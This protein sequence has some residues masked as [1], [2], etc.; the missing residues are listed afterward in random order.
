MFRPSE[1]IIDWPLGHLSHNGGL[2]SLNVFIDRPD[3]CG[4]HH[5]SHW[6]VIPLSVLRTP[7]SHYRNEP[8]TPDDVNPPTLSESPPL[9]PKYCSHIV[10]PSALPL[11]RSS[12]GP[13]PLLPYLSEPL[14]SPL[15]VTEP[16]AG[17]NIR[18]P[19][20]YYYMR[21]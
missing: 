3:T 20:L 1:Q 5:I 2:T 13:V 9:L 8:G 15:I 10:V 6:G 16:S 7:I 18:L 21:W 4:L 14:I 19:N 11:Y 12:Q 17:C